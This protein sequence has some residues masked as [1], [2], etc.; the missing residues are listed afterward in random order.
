[1]KTEELVIGESKYVFHGPLHRK[2]KAPYKI[3]V[4]KKSR[5]KT[6]SLLRKIK[7]FCKSELNKEKISASLKV[8]LEEILA[9]ANTAHDYM[10][11]MKSRS[12]IRITRFDSC[13]SKKQIEILAKYKIRNLV[14][15]A[16]VP[17]RTLHT[18]LTFKGNNKNNPSFIIALGKGKFPRKT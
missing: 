11:T 17:K 15:V 5:R 13:L 14:D 3:T 18:I 2:A 6:L 7:E 12:H 10:K 4:D 9:V 8:Q 1:M 16:I